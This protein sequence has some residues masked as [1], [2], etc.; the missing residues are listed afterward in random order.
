MPNCVGNGTA[1][2]KNYKTSHAKHVT[3]MPQTCHN[4]PQ[5]PQGCMVDMPK[6]RDINPEEEATIITSAEDVITPDD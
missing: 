5:P 1:T 6:L 4:M 2:K 3:N